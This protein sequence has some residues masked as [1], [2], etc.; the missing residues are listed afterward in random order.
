MNIH[1]SEAEFKG[2]RAVKLNFSDL[3]ILY[4]LTSFVWRLTRTLARIKSF[5]FVKRTRKPEE[6]D[7]QPTDLRSLD[8]IR[9]YVINLRSPTNS[10]IL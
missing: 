1:N 4:C 3:C 6:K 8:T 2:D 10:K 7:A 9:V 5:L